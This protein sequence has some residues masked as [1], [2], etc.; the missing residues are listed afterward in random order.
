MDI[1][2]LDSITIA[3]NKI[4][5]AMEKDLLDYSIILF[6]CLSAL[7]T[8]W[9]VFYTR[10]TISMIKEQ[11]EI[12][13]LPS[14]FM[15]DFIIK[16]PF[17]PYLGEKKLSEAGDSI[18]GFD[19]SGLEMINV[20]NGNAKAIKCRFHF[21]QKNIESEIKKKLEK[22][23]EELSYVMESSGSPE[24]ICIYEKNARVFFD[25]YKNY[26]F[27]TMAILS[28]NKVEIKSFPTWYLVVF[29]FLLEKS[30]SDK[31]PILKID[32]TYFDIYN[33]KYCCYFIANCPSPMRFDKTRQLKFEVTLC[34]ESYVPIL[35][36]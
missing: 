5:H 3:L 32:L 30:L 8:L 19:V 2:L 22:D 10:K 7:A 25:G 13:I 20:G 35:S 16:Y 4:T 29:F 21:E 12:N 27:S 1:C 33:N 14:L 15:S 11:N 18:K 26:N 6:N 34:N 23:N 17:H 28:G 9:M 31:I 36:S 24:E